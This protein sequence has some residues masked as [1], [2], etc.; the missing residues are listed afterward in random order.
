MVD[1]TDLIAINQ[2]TDE[3]GLKLATVKEL[4]G[5]GT[6]K[7]QFYGEDTPSEKEYS[8]LA[9]YTPAVNDTVL[10]IPMA[11]TYIVLGKILYSE[12]EPPADYITPEQ[13]NT[14]LTEYVKSNA[15]SDYAKKT[16]LE[17]YFKLSTNGTIIIGNTGYYNEMY[18]LMLH[19]DFWHNGN[20]LG[21]F[22]KSPVSKTSLGTVSTSATLPQ[23][24]GYINNIV[25]L[26]QGYGLC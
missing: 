7:I 16:D 18:S 3:K 1:A 15:L 11:E 9:S 20:M 12:V 6:V 5:S 24:L 8:Y 4:F 26:L 10:L 23:A 13:L 25:T 22:G 14:A 21:F 17:G 19:K 2:E